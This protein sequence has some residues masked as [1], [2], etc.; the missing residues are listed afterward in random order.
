MGDLSIGVASVGEVNDNILNVGGHARGA[1]DRSG[2]HR[3]TF[4]NSGLEI[5]W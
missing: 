5:F 1:V 2:F 3:E 4:P